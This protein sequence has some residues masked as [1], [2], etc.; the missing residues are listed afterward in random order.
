MSIFPIFQTF[1][2]GTYPSI[3]QKPG[4]MGKPSPG[5]DLRVSC[6]SNIILTSSKERLTWVL[7]LSITK[8][9]YAPKSLSERLA[10]LF[11]LRV[12]SNYHIYEVDSI[13]STT[14]TEKSPQ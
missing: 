11:R 6:L 10:I 3:K 8:L 5:I 4:S 1:I 13:R 2:C 9:V 7:R 12:K 14:V